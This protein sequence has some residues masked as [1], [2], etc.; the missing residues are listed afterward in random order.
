M[1]TTTS[2]N[3][4]AAVW[5]ERVG[6]VGLC[7]GGVSIK[8]TLKL[9]GN[10]KN[11]RLYDIACGNGLLARKFIKSGAKEVY[12]SDIAPALIRIAQEEYNADG[13]TYLVRD[14]SNFKDIPK[15]YFDTVVI[16]QGIFYISDI[17]KL[18]KGVSTILKPG[19]TFV[20]TLPHPLA[21]EA[22]VA[23]GKVR[24]NLKELL[25]V[26]ENYLKSYSVIVKKECLGKNVTYKTY[27]RSLSY[28]VNLCGNNNLHISAMCE[29]FSKAKGLNGKSSRIPHY[30]VIKAIKAA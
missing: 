30:M 15:N 28:Y 6:D 9:V 8:E 1:N 18:M 27:K 10:L 7:I 26:Q 11:K 14:G 25:K 3:S 17:R 24:K 22:R 2:F 21:L 20:F 23:S 16:H 13:I 19:G 29:F 4:L 12:A 5:N